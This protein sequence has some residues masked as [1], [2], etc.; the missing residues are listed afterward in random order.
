MSSTGIACSPST[1]THRRTFSTPTRICSIFRRA[2]EEGV[3]AGRLQFVNL[4]SALG[5][6]L[7]GYPAVVT[8]A[9]VELAAPAMHLSLRTRTVVHLVLR[10]V[11]GLEV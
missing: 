10:A 5:L 6:H 1:A 2:A 9:L 4:P 11:P 8:D 3:S 7:L